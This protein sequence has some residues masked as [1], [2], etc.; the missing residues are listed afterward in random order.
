MRILWVNPV[1]TPDHDAGIAALLRQT[2]SAETLAEVVSLVPGVVPEHLEYD[3]FEAMA[4]PEVVRLSRQ[5]SAEGWD[6][7]IIGCFYDTAVTAA[8]EVSGRMIV[9]GPCLAGLQTAAHLAAR[10]SIIATRPKAAGHIARVVRGHGADHM[11]ASIRTLDILTSDLVR[12]P[13]L[14]ARRIE[15]EARAAVENDGA[16]AILL[17]CTLEHGAQDEIQDRIGVPVIDAVR[18]PFRMA[19][20]L[21]GL[22][23]LGWSPGR[24]GAGLA[25]DDDELGMTG[26]FGAAAIG[27]RIEVR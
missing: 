18:A 21:C 14:T 22:A 12:D 24:I 17:G 10:C 9:L 4:V 23:A 11:V 27:N 13:G 1:G 26:C 6:A 2:K 20:H 15:E 25:P 7:M 8:R 3:S 5:A 19:E 16:E